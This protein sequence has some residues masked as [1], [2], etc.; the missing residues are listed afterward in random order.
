MPHNTVVLTGGRIAGSDRPADVGIV[1]GRIVSIGPGASERATVIDVA[2]AV[3]AP[4]F[5]DMQING[6]FGHDFTRNPQSIWTVGE[7]LRRHGTTAFLPT[8]VSTDLDQIERAQR[9]VTAGPPAGY[10][11]ASVW[12]LHVE[13]PFLAP[14]RCGA[15]DES[16]LRHPS[17][18]LV[19]EWSPATGVTMVT[20]AP[21]LPGALATI[22][23]L[24]SHGVV[25]SLGHS[26]ATY[27]QAVAALDAGAT[28]VTHLFNAMSGTTHRSPGLAT[29]AL[30]DRRA[31]ASLIVDDIHL[32]R[33]TTRAAWNAL[34]PTRTM[35][36]TD[37]IAAAGDD[38]ARSAS[39]LGSHEVQLDGGAPRL[40][41]GVLAGS[42]LTLDD[43]A[44]N[45]HRITN[46]T[47]ADV[48][49]TVT[50][51]P[52]SLVGRPRRV[53]VGEAADLTVIGDDF[54]VVGTV[55]AGDLDDALRDRAR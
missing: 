15:H 46:A 42:L 30:A 1:G 40:A 24:V 4:G 35:L 34:G 21:E 29:A 8:L 54:G 10:R 50:T 5:V 53:A 26:D 23:T 9:V 18:A 39:L 31:T 2:G 3:V 6:G 32:H 52:A 22:A 25:V 14:T 48:V 16:K 7:G 27:E 49:A 41:G 19:G 47:V 33:G 36:I 55:V 51:T 11:G 44:R 37:A 12:G 38:P 28:A 13:G 43:A 45:L 17:P 20:L